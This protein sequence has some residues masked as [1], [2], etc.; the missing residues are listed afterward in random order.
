MN[1]T[2]TRAGRAAQG[3]IATGQ[4]ELIKTRSRAAGG[5]GREFPNVR[6]ASAEV[7]TV[8]DREC[9]WA[10]TRSN[11]AGAG[12]PASDRTGTRENAVGRQRDVARAGTAAGRV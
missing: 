9:T 5:V 10:I 6:A 12:N 8:A 1:F 11:T 4:R 7:Q 3:E 2:N